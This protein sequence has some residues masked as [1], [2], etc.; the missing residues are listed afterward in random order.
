MEYR[1]K[2]FGTFLL[3]GT[4]LVGV[5]LYV[6][7]F[8]IK[9]LI[10]HNAVENAKNMFYADRDIFRLYIDN[11]EATLQAFSK[12]DVLKTNIANEKAYDAVADLF[13]TMAY[14]NN[15]IQN[16]TF[17]D[18]NGDEKVRV[19]RNVCYA[20]PYRVSKSQLQ[21]KSHRPYFQKIFA[22]NRGEIWISRLDL[23]MEHHRIER[24]YKPVLRVGMSLF[25]NGKKVGILKVN[26]F[27][28]KVLDIFASNRFYDVYIVDKEG[29]F[30]LHPNKR[31][32]FS[33]YL[34]TKAR[35]D[36][37]FPEAQAILHR[38]IYEGDLL[39]AARLPLLNADEL[40]MIVVPTDK[41][42]QFKKEEILK[43]I[44]LVFVLLTFGSVPIAYFLARTPARLQMEAEQAGID[45]ERKVNEKTKELRL[46]TQN[47]ERKVKERTKEQDVLLSLFDLGDAVLFKW[48]NDE[49]WSVEYVS[50][51]VE[52][53]LGYAP[54]EF[55]DQKIR[56]S[57]CIYPEDLPRVMQEVKQAIENKLYFFRHNPYRVVTK[58]GDVK[59][60]LDETVIVRNEKREVVNFV[61]YLFD[62][63]PIKENELKMRRLSI[64]DALTQVYNRL[65]LDELLHKHYY[66][67]LRNGEA[68][69]LIMLDIDHF[70]N[71]NDKYGH[72]VGDA[73]LRRFTS[74]ISK[75]IR[76][77]DIFGRW[78]GEEFLVIA[79][80]T[81][82]KEAKL[83][84]EKLRMIIE[85]TAFDGV[86]EGLT[87][88]FGV[89]QCD[90]TLSLDGNI[91]KADDALYR[92]KQNGRNQ[93][94]TA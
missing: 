53:L 52:K 85:Q 51:S 48:R 55:L 42:L 18:R 8:I 88:S 83:L 78:G 3:F 19:D 93:V 5:T 43:A 89:T 58:E 41:V 11:F 60:I 28:S 46:L 90:K 74:I 20:V 33:R 61:G 59:W 75:N 7:S 67:L 64:T 40:R 6:S 49:S 47:L 86:D 39:Y 82:L 63:T 44:A 17:I 35:L 66:N 50:R 65:F 76:K 56:Y 79:P 94:Q 31:Y 25:A 27:M 87:V 12:S 71:I 34:D 9:N 45:L 30:I 70:K 36:Q 68:C 4:V 10:I 81:T 15:F 21:N 54:S 37:F 29:Y 73:V 16:I 2:L 77:S 22:L 80:S 1:K 13:L 84:A 91:K 92:S 38:D 57:E 69:S 72:L 32:N 26:F 62:I 14:A 24:P 23:N